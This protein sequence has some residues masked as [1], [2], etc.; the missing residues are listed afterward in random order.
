MGWGTKYRWGCP[1]NLQSLYAHTSFHDATALLDWLPI[2]LSHR[3]GKS[4]TTLTW[5]ITGLADFQ[6][7]ITLWTS[8][9]WQRGR[10]AGSPALAAECPVLGEERKSISGR[11]RSD[12]SQQ[13]SFDADQRVPFIGKYHTIKTPSPKGSAGIRIATQHLTRHGYFI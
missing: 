12:F 4:P 2:A 6:S 11:G 5:V 9:D 10:V 13:R 1:K 8:I 7:K 3:L